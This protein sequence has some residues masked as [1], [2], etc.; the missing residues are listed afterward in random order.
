MW[1]ALV[2]L[3]SELHTQLSARAL[4]VTVARTIELTIHQDV[5]RVGRPGPGPGTSGVIPSN[6]SRLDVFKVP[7]QDLQII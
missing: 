5:S 6:G 3:I 7:G 2:A 1:S 4:G